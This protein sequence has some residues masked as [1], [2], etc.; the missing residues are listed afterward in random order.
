MNL[1]S[2]VQKTFFLSNDNVT[3]YAGGGTE[4]LNRVVFCHDGVKV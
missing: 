3:C 2:E 4:A 1:A